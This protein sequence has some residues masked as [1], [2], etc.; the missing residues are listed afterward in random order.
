[1][2][3]NFAESGTIYSESRIICGIHMNKL[4]N[5]VECAVAETAVYKRNPKIVSGFRK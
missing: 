2:A 5:A 3:V 4:S 1:M